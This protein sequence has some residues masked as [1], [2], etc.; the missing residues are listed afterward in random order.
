MLLASLKACIAKQG[1]MIPV[2]QKHYLVHTVATCVTYEMLAMEHSMLSKLSFLRHVSAMACE[3][4][5]MQDHS[6]VMLT[7]ATQGHIPFFCR[8]R[9]GCALQSRTCSP[10]RITYNACTTGR[11]AS[12]PILNHAAAT[13]VMIKACWNCKQLLSKCRHAVQVVSPIGGSAAMPHYRY[14]RCHPSY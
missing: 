11:A 10:A 6:T 9:L 5:A 12:C 14:T 13:L 8:Q 2:T 7:A 3:K 1:C 4:P